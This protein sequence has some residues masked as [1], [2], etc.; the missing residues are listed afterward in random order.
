MPPPTSRP[1]VLVPTSDEL[2]VAFGVL[3]R[4]ARAGLFAVRDRSI[5]PWAR[6]MADVLRSGAAIA[7]PLPE[8]ELYRPHAGGRVNIVPPGETWDI[9]PGRALIDALSRAPR[10][11]PVFPDTRRCECAGPTFKRLSTWHRDP[12]G[13]DCRV[14]GGFI[15][16]RKASAA[17]APEDEPRATR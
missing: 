4:A 11:G 1:P 12:P 2:A 9:R 6:G 8:P 3:A 17:L 14:C 15:D 13:W 5:P 10:C 16:R 7:P